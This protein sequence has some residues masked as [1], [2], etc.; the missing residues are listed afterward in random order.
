MTLLLV[1]GQ[2]GT[3]EYTEDNVYQRN[4][5]G[6]TVVTESDNPREF[7]KWSE[8]FQQFKLGGVI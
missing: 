2:S 6:V 8:R 1:C 7:E 5:Q 3:L 4:Y